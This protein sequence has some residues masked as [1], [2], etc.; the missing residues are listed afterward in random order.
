MRALAVTVV[1]LTVF[2][3]SR[4]KFVAKRQLPSLTDRPRPENQK[5][6]VLSYRWEIMAF[7]QFNTK[8]HGFLAYKLCKNEFAFTTQG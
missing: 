4:R 2:V 6:T 7:K 8:I 3:I 5:D 1:P